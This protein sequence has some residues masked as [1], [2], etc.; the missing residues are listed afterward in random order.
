MFV[1]CVVSKGKMQDS[2]DQE[3][4]DVQSTSE[5]KRKIPLR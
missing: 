5:Y 4:D 1:L 3:T 2:Q